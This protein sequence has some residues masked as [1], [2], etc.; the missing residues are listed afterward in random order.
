MTLCLAWKKETNI[1]LLSDSRLSD[2]E[3]ILTDNANKVFTINVRVVNQQDRQVVFDSA[4]GMCFAGSYL[5]GSNLANT[6]SELTSEI[7]IEDGEVVNFDKIAEIAFILYEYISRHLMEINRRKGLSEVFFIGY[8]PEAK[9][10]KINKFYSKIGDEGTIEFQ[11]QDIELKENEL[12]YLGDSNAI[13]AAKELEGK[14]GY[15]YTEFHLISEI[16]NNKEVPTVGGGIQYGCIVANKFRTYGIVDYELYEPQNRS[17]Y[18]RVKEMFT[19][20]SI[21]F[22]WEDSELKKIKVS[23][24]KVFMAPYVDKKASLQKQS[25]EKNNEKE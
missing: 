19:F 7:E 5:N 23:L 22:N 10:N 4:Y 9:D 25:D 14:I 2:G 20:R 6:I 11:R 21:P 24:N 8:C 3:T 13:Q 17:E 1:S 16:I 15:P 12:V 18:F